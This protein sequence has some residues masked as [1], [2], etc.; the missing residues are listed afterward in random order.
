MCSAPPPPPPNV[1]P[2]PTTTTTGTQEQV[3]AA[4]RTNPDCAVCHDSMD[5]IGSALENYDAVGAWRTQDNGYPVDASGMFAGAIADPDGGPGASFVGGVALAK[6]VAADRGCYVGIT[7]AERHLYVSHAWSRMLWGNTSSNIPSR[8]LNEIPAELVRDVV[9]DR[10]WGSSGSGYGRGRRLRTPALHR[11]TRRHTGPLG[12]RQ[13]GVAAG[14]ATSTPTADGGGP[15]PRRGPSS[16]GWRWATWS[17]TASGARDAWC[18]P[19]ARATTP[20]PRSSSP[21][22]GARSCSCGWPRSSAP[23]PRRRPAPSCRR[24]DPVVGLGRTPGCRRRRPRWER[25]DPT[26]SAGDGKLGGIALL[27]DAA[28]RPCRAAHRPRRGNEEPG[29]PCQAPLSTTRTSR[30]SAPPASR[31]SSP[32]PGG[33]RPAPP[34]APTRCP[35]RPDGERRALRKQRI[36]ERPTPVGRHPKTTVF[37]VAMILLSPVWASHG[38]GGHQPRPRA[39]TG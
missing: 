26:P 14:G 6:A 27:P 9:V 16:S 21:R 10:G 2:F 18:R 29:P 36:R 22:S 32:C 1:P 3:L 11:G 23:E 13:R 25:V 39:D 4:H 30:S 20:R 33:F 19:G 8:F 28:R 35:S 12:L 5:N 38:P 15:R 17:S 24:Q 37:V 31:W 7:R 34:A